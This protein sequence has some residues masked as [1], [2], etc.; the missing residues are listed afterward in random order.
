[1][2]K[3]KIY[4]KIKQ[5]ELHIIGSLIE[6]VK[7]N[8]K[9]RIEILKNLFI[10]ISI[11]II[12]FMIFLSAAMI[13]VKSNMKSS[14]EYSVDAILSGEVNDTIEHRFFNILMQ[15]EKIETVA[16]G[17]VSVSSTTYPMHF[18]MPILLALVATMVVAVI[19]KILQ[20]HFNKKLL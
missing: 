7:M 5:I 6:V 18:I 2:V 16:N 19:F 11:F 20:K 14:K 13:F 9:V 1:M 17:G 12:I 15:E 4:V 3:Y 10:K 8:K